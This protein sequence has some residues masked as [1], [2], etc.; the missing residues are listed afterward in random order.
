VIYIFEYFSYFLSINTVFDNKYLKLYYIIYV[1]IRKVIN[2]FIIEAI[3][4]YYLIE[5]NIRNIAQIYIGNI[6]FKKKINNLIIFLNKYK[7]LYIINENRIIIYDK[8]NIDINKSYGKKYGKQLGLFY[9]CATNNFSKN[10][11]RIV[12]KLYINNNDGRDIELYAQKC[13][14]TQIMK[15]FNDIYNF[16]SKI[17]NV[18]ELFDKNIFCLIE[19]YNTY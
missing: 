9:K 14:E 2:S 15:Y 10:K 12:I 6:K 1:I 11:V 19:I 5:K 3:I 4:Q 13:N 8:N 16:Y 7:I 17:N 18:L